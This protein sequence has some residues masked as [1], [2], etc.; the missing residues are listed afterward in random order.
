MTKLPESTYR[1]L[2]YKELSGFIEYDLI[3]DWAMDMLQYGYETSNILILSGLSK[4]VTSFEI[5]PYFTAALSE[6]GLNSIS[7]KGEDSYALYLWSE[8]HIL[9]TGTNVR[10]QLYRLC[11][12]CIDF[13]Y[14]IMLMDFYN[15]YWA[16]GDLEYYEG[17]KTQYYWEKELDLNN[18]EQYIINHAKEWCNIYKSKFEQYL[19]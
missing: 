12:A 10:K 15:L 9:L 13:D 4:P 17:G 11:Q 19:S 7:I 1:I 8:V 5:E 2:A 16:W 6:L 3:V 18:I 14:P